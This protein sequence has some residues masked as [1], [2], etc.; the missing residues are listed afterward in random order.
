[1]NE[2]ERFMGDTSPNFHIHVDR[3]TYEIIDRETHDFDLYE[4]LYITTSIGRCGVRIEFNDPFCKTMERFSFLARSHRRYDEKGVVEEVKAYIE[5]NM[6]FPE[7]RWRNLQIACKVRKEDFSG[8]YKNIFKKAV[9][10]KEISD[11]EDM[12]EKYTPKKENPEREFLDY[13]EAENILSCA[14]VF[15]DFGIDDEFSRDELICEFMEL[16]NR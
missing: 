10:E 3:L 2:L 7:G 8:W 1:M 11:Y 5:K 9:K 4:R 6:L 13:E 15:F 16:C 12:I 14:G